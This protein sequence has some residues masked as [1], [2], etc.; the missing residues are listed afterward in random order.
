MLVNSFVFWCFFAAFL[1]PYFTLM[2]GQSRAQNV[3]LLVASYFFYGYT[4]W[5][6]TIL[7][8]IATI[9]FYFLGLAINKVS[10]SKSQVSGKTLMVL[11][12]ILGVGMLLYFKYLNF[13]VEQFAAL[14]ALMGLKTNFSSSRELSKVSSAFTPMRM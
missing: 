6:M 8:L 12:V 11:G 9:T 1:L 4:D 2:R 7:L 10:G 5:R 13:F 14:F 3:W